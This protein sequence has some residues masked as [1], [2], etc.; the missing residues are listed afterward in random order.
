MPGPLYGGSTVR[1]HS[2]ILMEQAFA[3]TFHCFSVL[4][5]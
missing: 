2:V 5:Q 3:S 4:S 1:V